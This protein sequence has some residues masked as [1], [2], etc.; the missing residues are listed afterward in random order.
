MKGSCLLRAVAVDNFHAISGAPKVF[1]HFL[2]DHD[3]AVLSAGSTECDRQIAL[4]FMNVVRQQVNEQVGDARDE[5]P[6]L[7]E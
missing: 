4:A 5:L 3:G 1:A 6:G 7:R 2:G